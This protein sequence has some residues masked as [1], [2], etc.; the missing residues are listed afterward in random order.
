MVMESFNTQG[1]TGGHGRMLS[2]NSNNPAAEQQQN[3]QPYSQINNVNHYNFSIIN[4]SPGNSTNPMFNNTTNL[5]DSLQS[6]IKG[7]APFS[8]MGTP[9]AS[10]NPKVKFLLQVIYIQNSAAQHNQS[11]K[12]TASLR[13]PPP[14]HKNSTTQQNDNHKF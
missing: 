12:S 1:A 3:G 7:N 6:I 2:I 8:H 13:K 10:N 4:N 5:T 11:L 14:S 9:K